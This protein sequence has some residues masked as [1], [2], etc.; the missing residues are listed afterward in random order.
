MIIEVDNERTYTPAWNNNRQSDEPI[1]IT[2][3]FLK[4][5]ERKKFIYT[6]P[7][8]LNVG[9]GTVSDEVDYIQDQEG[10]A[11]ALITKI[12]NLKVKDKKS[13]KVI[14]VK[15]INTFYQT[16]GIPQALVSEI[17]NYILTASPEVDTD[18]L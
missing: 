2:H 9:E 14:E 5:G 15:D 16:S 17:E 7:I 3:R 18:F 8:R 11:K 10:I 4:A 13:D 12:E 1:V 6:K